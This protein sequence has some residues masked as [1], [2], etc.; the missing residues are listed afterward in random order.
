MTLQ[1]STYR[2]RSATAGPKTVERQVRNIGST[3]RD[4]HRRAQS[5]VLVV[6]ILTEAPQQAI[7]SGLGRLNRYLLRPRRRARRRLSCA[8]SP[9]RST[10]RTGLYC[11]LPAVNAS[12]DSSRRSWPIDMCIRCGPSR[13][14][15]IVWRSTLTDDRAQKTNGT[16]ADGKSLLTVPL[17]VMTVTRSVCWDG[18]RW[19]MWRWGSPLLR[20]SR[21]RSGA[22]QLL[23]HVFR[24]NLFP[25]SLARIRDAVDAP[26]LSVLRHE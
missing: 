5:A 7:I 16:R 18:G 2:H 12:K 24:L 19:A 15:T 8:E 9:T 23:D 21:S 4:C 22:G 20:Q 13:A 10:K 6:L 26:F 3:P 17:T 1:R 14:H 25:N 11:Q